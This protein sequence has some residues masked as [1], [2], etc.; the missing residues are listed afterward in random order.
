MDMDYS[1]VKSAVTTQASLWDLIH[2]LAV[3]DG[4]LHGK[5]RGE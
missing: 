4:L 1:A 2:L 5:S 3:F